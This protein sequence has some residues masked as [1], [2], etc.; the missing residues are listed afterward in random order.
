M[1]VIRDMMP[2]FEL[3]QPTTIDEAVA[4]LAR[5]GAVDTGPMTLKSAGL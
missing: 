5:Q 3:F 2:A 4:L 1:A